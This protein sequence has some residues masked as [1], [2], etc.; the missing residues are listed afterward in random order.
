[1]TRIT[2]RGID[3]EVD[4]TYSKAEPQTYDYPGCPEEALINGVF[5]KGTDFSNFL[6]EDDYVEIEELLLR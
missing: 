3:F 6:T 4:W 1:M 2:L 5:H